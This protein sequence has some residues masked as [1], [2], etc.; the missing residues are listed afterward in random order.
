MRIALLLS[1][2]DLTSFAD[3]SRKLREQGRKRGGSAV[4]N[5]HTV[6]SI[7]MEA[8]RMKGLGVRSIL[9]M[10]WWSRIAERLS[11]PRIE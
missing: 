3:L 2:H 6:L 7:G 8:M 9:V 5:S 11:L 1:V 10:P 4:D